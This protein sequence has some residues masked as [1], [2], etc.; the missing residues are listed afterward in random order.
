M[1]R[2]LATDEGDGCIMK[3]QLHKEAMLRIQETLLW[4][5]LI[6]P[7]CFLVE[8]MALE[9]CRSLS[10]CIANTLL[11]PRNGKTELDLV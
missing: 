2:D 11:P 6:L 5:L 1:T 4:K 7:T 8:V 3:I 10:A 9:V